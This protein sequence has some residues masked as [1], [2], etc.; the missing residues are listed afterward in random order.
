M[1]HR[2]GLI[3]VSLASAIVLLSGCAERKTQPGPDT[4]AQTTHVCSSCHG[5]DGRSITPFFPSLAGQ[6]KDYLVAQ[7]KAFREKKRADPHAKTYMFGM[8][9]RLDDATIDGLAAYY[10]A[11]P[12]PPPQQLAP[13]AVLAGQAIV[14]NG[15]DS[16][17]VPAC[18]GCHGEKSEGAGEIPR[19]AGQHPEYIVDQLLAF[20]S[21]ERDNEEMYENAINLT[22]EE[23]EQVATYFAAQP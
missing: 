9:A 17:N 19:L 15:V 3:G 14:A 22:P 23:V 16:R 13:D 10:S 11:L 8:A 21:K 1:V 18:S 12:A 6:Q 2:S 20:K 5:L 7:L 4:I